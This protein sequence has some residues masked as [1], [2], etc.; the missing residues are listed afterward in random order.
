[1][2]DVAAD[3]R[4]RFDG[5]SDV[6]EHVDRIDED[7]HCDTE[8]WLL[9]NPMGIRT[10]REIHAEL[11]GATI[12]RRMYQKTRCFSLDYPSSSVDASVVQVVR[13]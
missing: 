1:V 6:F 13:D 3:M 5:Y 9:N 8:G 2:L 12:Y 11:E 4:E 7:L 10:E